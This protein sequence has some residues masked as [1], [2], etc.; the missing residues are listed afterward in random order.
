VV[1]LPRVT[2][3]EDG[4]AEMEK[5]PEVEFT[6]NVTVVEWLRLPLVPVIVKV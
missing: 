2:V 5:L 3:C 6:T 1:L 4:E